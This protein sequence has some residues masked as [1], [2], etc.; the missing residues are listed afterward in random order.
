MAEIVPNIVKFI[1][2]NDIFLW[3]FVK[4]VITTLSILSLFS[5]LVPKLI[6]NSKSLA[7]RLKELSQ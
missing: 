1:E 7:L 4:L 2:I 3:K 6:K 5:I